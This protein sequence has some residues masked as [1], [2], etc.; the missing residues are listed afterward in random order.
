MKKTKENEIPTSFAD[1]SKANIGVWKQMVARW[2]EDKNKNRS[3]EDMFK[4]VEY[5]ARAYAE[6]FWL[7]KEIENWLDLQNKDISKL[8]WSEEKSE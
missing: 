6:F 4:E 8:E 5:S 7:D 1:V 3:L 2:K